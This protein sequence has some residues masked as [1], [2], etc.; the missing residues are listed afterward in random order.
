MQDYNIEQQRLKMNEQS[1]VNF[2]VGNTN[3]KD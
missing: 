1:G 3:M 2:I